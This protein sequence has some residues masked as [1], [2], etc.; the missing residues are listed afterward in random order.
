[1]LAHDT[2]YFDTQ[3]QQRQDD[4]LLDLAADG[5]SD[6]WEGR[7]PELPFDSA[8]MSGFFRGKLA[9]TELILEQCQSLIESTRKRY[10]DQQSKLDYLSRTLEI[11][12]N[13]V[14]DDEGEF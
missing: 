9:K 11:V 1:M 8:Y 2:E 3:Y 12:V 13:R 5:A 14:S 4:C 7:E 6:G 10:G